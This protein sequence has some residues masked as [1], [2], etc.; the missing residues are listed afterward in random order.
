MRYSEAK[1]K[2]WYLDN[3]GTQW[4]EEDDLPDTSSWTPA[5]KKVGALLWE[6]YV[7][8]KASKE[9]LAYQTAAAEA[10]TLRAKRDAIQNAERLDRAFAQTR[11]A[12]RTAELGIAD[13]IRADQTAR[14]AD[15]LSGL[16]KEGEITRRKLYD[17]YAERMDASDL[18]VQDRLAKLETEQAQR[19]QKEWETL[20]SQLDKELEGYR[21]SYDNSKITDE[22]IE[23]AR[24]KIEAR[25][26][27]LGDAYEQATRWLD[28]LPAYKADPNKVWVSTYL[29]EK[30]A[31]D[32]WD[33][34]LADVVKYQGGAGSKVGKIDIF[35]VKDGDTTYTI[36]SGE[37]VD[38]NTDALLKAIANAKSVEL[39]TGQVLYYRG[40]LY[41]YDGV[42]AFRST[43]VAFSSTASDGLNRLLR[44]LEVKSYMAREEQQ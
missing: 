42:G 36:K 23:L 7:A 11:Q 32:K 1:W 31:V 41:V 14:L 24:Q 38:Q 22:G 37:Y 6:K 5:Q 12:M 9:D 19:E 2:K 44:R 29:G 33:Y 3:T 35:T 20:K 4:N 10:S 21:S 27:D 8:D 39:S 16:Q 18:D 34:Q 17:N 28:E 40:K 26:D 43:R 30:V 13:S 25:R 15:T